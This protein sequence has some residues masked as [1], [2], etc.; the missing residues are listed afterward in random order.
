MIKKSRK[1]EQDICQSIEEDLQPFCVPVDVQLITAR[2][3][4][5]SVHISELS[6][7]MALFKHKGV[8][9]T[10]YVTLQYIMQLII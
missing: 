4:G 2:N 1:K 8:H 7:R 3:G 9:I 5:E 10:I 6:F